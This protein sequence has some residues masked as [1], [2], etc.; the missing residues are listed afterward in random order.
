MTASCKEAVIQLLIAY[1]ANGCVAE[2]HCDAASDNTHLAIFR[3]SSM[4][5]SCRS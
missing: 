1:D 5:Q 3:F 2:A 4:K